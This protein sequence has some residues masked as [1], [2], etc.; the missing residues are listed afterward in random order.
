MSGT[1]LTMRLADHGEQVVGQAGQSAVMKSSVVAARRASALASMQ[2]IAHDADAPHGQQHAKDLA[3]LA[4]EAGARQFGLEEDGVAALAQAVSSRSQVT[5]PMMRM[6]R[7]S[8]GKG[9]RQH[10]SPPAAPAPRPRC[11]PRP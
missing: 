1:S 11:A 8:T 3:R 5:S 6:A 10:R 7:P 2:A 4:V 9:W